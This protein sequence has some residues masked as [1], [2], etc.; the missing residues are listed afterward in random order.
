MSSSLSARAGERIGRLHHGVCDL[1]S[2]AAW[3]EGIVNLRIGFLGTG[4]IAWAHSLALKAMKD[5]GIV[6]VSIEACF[7]SDANRSSG[8]ASIQGC[9]AKDS[10][11]EVLDA[12]DAVWICTSTAAHRELVA[13]ACEKGVAV[14]C[15]KP[16]G[17]NLEEAT[18]IGDLVAASGIPAQVGLVLR[19]CPVFRSLEAV[20]GSGEFGRLMAISLRDDQFFPIQGHYGSTWRADVSKAGGGTVI[21]HSIHDLDILRFCVDVPATISATTSCF[22]G[23]EG[24]EDSAVASISFEGGASGVL[25]STWHQILSRPS[26]R[27]V[28]AIFE[29]GIVWFEDDFTGPMHIINDAGNEVRVCDSPDWVTELPLSKDEI[30]LAIRMYAAADRGFVDALM[31]GKAP[32]PSIAEGVFAHK[33]VEA[34]YASARGGGVPIDPRSL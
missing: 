26:T 11:G 21:E 25:V 20:I 23:Y 22:S 31:A 1:G 4:L 16:L 24:I 3:A 34:V 7:D 2:K 14:F 17:R 28:E 6:D 9:S 8:F 12:V 30:G 10:P 15:E 29:S 18:A 19:S 32:S 27:R 13:L 5:S 33:L